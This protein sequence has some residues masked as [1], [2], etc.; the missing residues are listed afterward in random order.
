MTTT[1]TT[2]QEAYEAIRKH[3]TQPGVQYGYDH[4]VSECCYRTPDGWVCAVGALIPE[5]LY[6]RLAEECRIEG[7]GV[8][9]L[10]KIPELHDLLNGDDPMG[11][12][13]LEFLT[14][15]Q[16]AHDYCAENDRPMGEFIR[17]LDERAQEFFL[18]VPA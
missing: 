1:I 3:F 8:K 17:R 18:H 4:E 9:M 14:A 12:I 13:K 2:A 11:Q 16:R 10:A 5:E 6:F 15:A 7:E